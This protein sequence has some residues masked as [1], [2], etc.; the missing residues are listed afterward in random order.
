ME[1]FNGQLIANNG[2]ADAYEGY[3]IYGLGGGAP[4]TLGF[5]KPTAAG[6]TGSQ[7]G[8]A[9]DGTYFLT[10]EIF[11]STLDVWNADGSFNEAISL[12][13][14]AND[15]NGLLI[16]DLSVNYATRADTSGAPDGGSTL[17]LLSIP[18]LLMAR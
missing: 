3:D 9:Y 4:T 14:I 2:D 5:I 7:T 6:R 18:A 11:N 16:E 12:P 13:G 10:S 15:G 1:W 8:I 17:L